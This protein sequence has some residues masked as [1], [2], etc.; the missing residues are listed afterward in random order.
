MKGFTYVDFMPVC[1][2]AA[3]ARQQRDAWLGYE[4]RDIND[5][6][7]ASGLALA[8][9]LSEAL[10]RAAAGKAAVGVEDGDHVFTRVN[11]GK[12]DLVSQV[13]DIG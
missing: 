12:V 11:E 7:D 4:G 9:F 2:L 10:D 1:P 13:V 3:E 5:S 6:E 8:V